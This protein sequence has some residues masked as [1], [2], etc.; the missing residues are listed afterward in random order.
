MI[1]SRK[2]LML[3]LFPGLTGFI[4]FWV[5]PVL[6]GIY[7]SMTSYLDGGKF[8]F[9]HNYIK[10]FEN[11]VFI[12]ALLNTFTI[13]FIGVALIMVSSFIIAYYIYEIFKL[14]RLLKVVLLPLAVAT[15]AISFVWETLFNVNGN[16]NKLLTDV[17]GLSAINWQSGA[18][19]FVPILLLY[20]WR[21]IG[22]NI[23]VFV[24]ALNTIPSEMS[25]VF[26]L[27]SKSNLKRIYYVIIP[28]VIPQAIFAFF[29]SLMYCLWL[30]QD[31][32][33][34]WK[35]YP[36]EQ[37]YLLQHFITNSFRKLN[38]ENAAAAS[39]VLIV[40]VGVILA[41]LRKLERRYDIQ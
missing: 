2:W 26:L 28:S 16:I 19:A 37:L 6:S 33:T 25:Q 27:D 5:Y 36:P 14:R 38:Y 3:L 7:I 41:L 30:S 20:I 34:L 40:I 9:L 22:I 18:W 13:T 21:Y 32:F 39:T 11:K 8:V 24:A 17:L 15:V 23:I 29:I 35:D 10:L 12:K 31:I 4:F 1:H